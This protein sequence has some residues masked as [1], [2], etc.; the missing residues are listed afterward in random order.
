MREYFNRN[1]VTI[2]LMTTQVGRQFAQSY[3]GGTLKHL[4]VG[5]GRG[6]G[7]GL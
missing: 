7:G 6:R 1:E 5:G 3:E 4:M 2:S